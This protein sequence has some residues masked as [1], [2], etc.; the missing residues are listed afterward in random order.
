LCVREEEEE[1][2][3]GRVLTNANAGGSAFVLTR[4]GE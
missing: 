1:E 2:E 4:V 3:G